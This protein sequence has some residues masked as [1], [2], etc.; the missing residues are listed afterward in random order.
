[1]KFIHVADLHFGKNI[2][3]LSMIDD[4][5]NWVEKFL[6]MCRKERPDA[7]VIEMCMTA[8]HLP[9][10]RWNCLTIC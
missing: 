9:V 5:K 8:A 10:Q 7:V 3:G 4:Q 1:M 6:D 2:Y